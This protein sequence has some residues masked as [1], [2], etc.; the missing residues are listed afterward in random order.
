MQVAKRL[1]KIA[2]VSS[3]EILTKF[4]IDGVE[5]KMSQGAN[6]W[7]VML[8]GAEENSRPPIQLD[9]D[10]KA[11]Y[12]SRLRHD[13]AVRIQ[14]AWAAYKQSKLVPPASTQLSIGRDM[15]LE[16]DLVAGSGPP[17]G[18]HMPSSIQAQ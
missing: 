9:F 16:S 15:P 14:A 18:P 17:L 3:V 10:F 12:T 2:A 4:H 7:M 6:M 13:A 5:K 11:D 1:Y 8:G